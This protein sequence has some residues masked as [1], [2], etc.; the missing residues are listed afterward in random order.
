MPNATFPDPLPSLAGRRAIV[1]GAAAGL[2]FETAR[3]LALAGADVVIAVRDPARGEAAAAAIRAE[4]ASAA[5]R[6]EQ[7][8]VAS[9]QSVRDF[10]RR[11]RDR[12]DAL[13]LVVHNAGIMAT[14]PTQTADGVEAQMATNHLGPFLLTAEL[15]PV[16]LHSK[17]ARV[18]TVTSDEAEKQKPEHL[19]ADDL[20]AAGGRSPWAWYGVTKL[21]S[22]AT[23]VELH[24]RAARAGVSIV[25]TAA[26]PGL[27]STGLSHHVAGGFMR[28]VVR[29]A[30]AVAGQ[31]ARGGARSL[32]HAAV[33]DDVRGGDLWAPGGFAG[34]RGKPVA[35]KLPAPATNAALRAELWDASVAL[36]GADFGA[37]S[38]AA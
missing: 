36:T 27:A 9:F 33:A 17:A 34:M 22:L 23:S 1:T 24:E 31:S 19:T 7:L 13:D 30:M 2:G 8:D 21:A 3:A 6:V 18:V 12:G 28:F 25:S 16:L 4:L 38:R 14:P 10:A 37:L 26:H 15:W 5:L 29:I 35:K 11:V 32:V 20:R